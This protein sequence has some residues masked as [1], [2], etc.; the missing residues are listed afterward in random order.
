MSDTDLKKSENTKKTK[1]STLSRKVKNLAMSIKKALGQDEE[2]KLKKR[3]EKERKRQ[4]REKLIKEMREAF[5]KNP[6]LI[7][8]IIQDKLGAPVQ[9]TPKKEEQELENLEEIELLEKLTETLKTMAKANPEC[10][11]TGEKK[12]DQDDTPTINTSR[13]DKVRG[14][15][16]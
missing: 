5:R 1:S 3:K 6:S 10:Q 15:S 9:K 12:E 13:D 14:I 7:N 16:L 2:T 8:D 4:E 11:G